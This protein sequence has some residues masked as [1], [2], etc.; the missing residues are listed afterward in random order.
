M[1]F[2][3]DY[4]GIDQKGSDCPVWCDVSFPA[5]DNSKLEGKLLEE[6]EKSLNQLKNEEVLFH[7]APIGF[8]FF[9]QHKNIVFC[10]SQFIDVLENFKVSFFSIP[11]RAY[12]QPKNRKE[13]IQTV[14]NYSIVV[15]NTIKCCVDFEKSKIRVERNKD[16]EVVLDDK[17]RKKIQ[18]LYNLVVDKNLVDGVDLFVPREHQSSII[19]SEDLFFGFKAANLRRLALIP[20]PDVN[21]LNLPS[22]QNSNRIVDNGSER[23]FISPLP[24]KQK[25]RLP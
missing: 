12:M 3:L 17:N 2:F 11:I 1:H 20:T 8:D 23:I 4:A 22:F 19:V 25:P 15:F 16:G 7:H 24:S 18:Y 13:K 9:N 5:F 21:L 14:K 6:N 10:S